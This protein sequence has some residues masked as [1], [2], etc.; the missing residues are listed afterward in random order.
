[1]Q[2]KLLLEVEEG[3]G[4]HAT[5][6]VHIQRVRQKKKDEGWVPEKKRDE[7]GI[8][9]SNREGRQARVRNNGSDS[10]ETPSE[11]GVRSGWKKTNKQ[12]RK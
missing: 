4:V 3:R 2:S 12:V 9:S 6:E 10:R 8:K 11:K 1:M 7:E 5:P